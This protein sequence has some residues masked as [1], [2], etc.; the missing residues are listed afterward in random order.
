[1]RRVFL[2]IIA[3]MAFCVGTAF[4]HEHWVDVSDFNPPEGTKQSVFLC[5][6]HAFPK[7]ET[8]LKDRVLHETKIIKPDGTTEEFETVEKGKRR[9]TEFLFESQGTY[10]MGFA[11]K[12]PQSK[13]PLYWAR[14]ICVAGTTGG[15]REKL[16]SS[17]KGLEILP[18]S[19]VSALKKGDQLPL[20]ITFDGA[21]VD[22]RLSVLPEKGKSVTLSTTA[23]RPAA[24]K[25]SATGRYLVTTAYKGK[26]CSLTF[27]VK[28]TGPDK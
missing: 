24:L 6:G 7:S 3:M 27:A 4:A 12:Q 26:G 9:V 10:V 13:E 19:K 20:V 25:I 16:Y 21:R 5:S 8:V 15:D 17:G 2:A 28:E 23:K 1:M 11:L 18:L 22:G 14:A